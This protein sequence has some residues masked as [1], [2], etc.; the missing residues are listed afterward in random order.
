MS[1]GMAGVPFEDQ[2][3]PGAEWGALKAASPYGQMP[4]LFVDGAPMAQARAILRYLGKILD[5]PDGKLYPE[6]P[7]QAYQCDEFIEHARAPMPATFAIA[8]AA[9]KEAARLALVTE[10]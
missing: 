9:E 1:F 2:H 4:V 6:D 10:G 8:D 3:V 5:G 7:M